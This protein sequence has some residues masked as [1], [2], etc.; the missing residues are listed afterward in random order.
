MRIEVGGLKTTYGTIETG[1]DGLIYTPAA[2]EHAAA[3]RA[4]I[5][6]MRWRWPDTR[7]VASDEDVLASLPARLRNP[8]AWARALEGV[9]WTPQQWIER[10][11]AAEARLAG[12]GREGGA[13]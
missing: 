12:K 6:R 9:P 11:D 13:S 3:L 8:Y 10:R 1:P 4:S 2:A 7:M 5:E